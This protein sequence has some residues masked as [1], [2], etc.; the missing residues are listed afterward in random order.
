MKHKLFF[1]LFLLGLNLAQ[2]Y[3]V[4]WIQPARYGTIAR[5]REKFT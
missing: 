5:M 1:F 2:P 4:G 3:G